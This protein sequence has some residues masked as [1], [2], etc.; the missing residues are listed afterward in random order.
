MNPDQSEMFTSSKRTSKR[1]SLC[2]LSAQNS[3]LP[4]VAT[5]SCGYDTN[6]ALPLLSTACSILSVPCHVIIARS[7]PSSR[8]SGR[9]TAFHRTRRSTFEQSG[10]SVPRIV[11]LCGRR[12]RPEWCP[13]KYYGNDL[14]FLRN[15]VTS[16]MLQ[17]NNGLFL[18][19]YR[20]RQKAATQKMSRSSGRTFYVL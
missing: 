18:L 12:D 16:G 13:S 14:E 17:V 6:V 9:R 19:R 20:R 7:R 11:L 15:S 8:S 5:R 4:S 3:V 2:P 1:R 10:L